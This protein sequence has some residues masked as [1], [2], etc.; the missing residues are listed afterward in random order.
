LQMI[1]SHH[2]PTKTPQPVISLQQH[3]FAITVI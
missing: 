1:P 2:S 3:L